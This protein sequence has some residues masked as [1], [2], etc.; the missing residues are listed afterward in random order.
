VSNDQLVWGDFGVYF[1]PYVSKISALYHQWE[2]HGTRKSLI[3]LKT[4]SGVQVD[5]PKRKPASGL[6]S[7]VGWGAEG[8]S[9]W[10]IKAGRLSVR[11]SKRAPHLS[12]H[13]LG[14]VT[15]G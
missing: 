9:R 15:Q 11:E 13:V 1:S 14:W 2:E 3:F 4:L 6:E 10:W 8:Q 5:L 12:S 7:M